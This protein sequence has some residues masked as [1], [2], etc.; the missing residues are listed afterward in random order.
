M[1]AYK[2]MVVKTVITETIEEWVDAESEQD[3]LNQ[4]RREGVEEQIEILG[5]VYYELT[6]YPC[7]PECETEENHAPL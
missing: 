2:F 6:V 3:A 4:L 5:C 7:P 1:P